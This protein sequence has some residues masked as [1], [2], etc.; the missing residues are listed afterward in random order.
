MPK[1]YRR[2]QPQYP[3]EPFFLYLLQSVID[4]FSDFLTEQ[5]N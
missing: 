1:Q 2:R 4:L 5:G 3:P